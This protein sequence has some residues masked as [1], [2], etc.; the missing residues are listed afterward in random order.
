MDNSENNRQELDL[1]VLLDDFLR[2]AKRLLLLGLVL[3]LLCSVGLT[4]YQQMRYTPRYE[5]TASF[6]V[7]VANPLFATISSY[8]SSTAEQ[9]A[10]TFPYILTSD[11][12]RQRVMEHL[13]MSYMPSLSV[14]ASASSNIITLK[15]MDSD[16]QRAQTVLEAVLAHYPEVAEFVVGPTKLILLDES[17][18]PTQSVNTFS[19]KSH[20]VKGAVIGTALWFLLAGLLALTKNTIHNED[21]LKQLLNCDCLGLIPGVNVGRKEVCPMIHRMKKEQGFPEAIRLLRLRVEKQMKEQ[22]KKIRRRQDYRIGE[23]GHFSGKEGQTGASDRLRS[24]QSFRG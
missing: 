5:A 8:N 13:G 7:R 14:T 16:P 24:A 21:E 18:V 23:S 15:V 9:M 3:I 20:L 4:G 17:G 6:T 2:E 12:L 11:V 22:G 19:F 1:L 10:K